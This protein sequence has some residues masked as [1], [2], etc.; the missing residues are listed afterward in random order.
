MSELLERAT[1][2]MAERHPHIDEHGMEAYAGFQIYM[3]EY[4]LAPVGGNGS[5][6]KPTAE[7][8]T[9]LAPTCIARTTLPAT[10]MPAGPPIASRP[11]AM[12]AMPPTIRTT[13]PVPD[14]MAPTVPVL[15]P[16]TPG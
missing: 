3:T 14:A 4:G 13:R 16:N 5:E 12:S 15:R 7:A 2:W 10:T 6:T 11:P 1:E 9:T 8:T